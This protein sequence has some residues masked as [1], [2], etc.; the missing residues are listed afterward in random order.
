M[1]RLAEETGLRFDLEEIV[2]LP[3]ELPAIGELE[4]ME[5]LPFVERDSGKTGRR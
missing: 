4:Q 5:L 3:E 2:R 1:E